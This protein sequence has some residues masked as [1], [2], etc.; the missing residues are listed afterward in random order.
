MVEQKDL[1]LIFTNEKHQNHNHSAE[2][3]SVKRPEL[4]RKRSTAKAGR[5]EIESNPILGWVTHKLRTICNAEVQTRVRVLNPL[6]RLSRLGVLH[7][8][9]VFPR[10]LALSAGGL[11]LWSSERLWEKDLLLVS[12][13]SYLTLFCDPV[14]C[15][16]PGSSVLYHLLSV[17]LDLCPLSQ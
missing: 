7:W 3:P 10:Y 15:S 1:E 12:H 6:L 11:N 16:S 5:L 17:C 9:V 8:E 13:K 2:Q 14:S 4:T